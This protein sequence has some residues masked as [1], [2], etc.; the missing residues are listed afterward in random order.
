MKEWKTQDRDSHEEE[1]IDTGEKDY[2]R[3]AGAGINTAIEQG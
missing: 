2:H 1:E 3:G